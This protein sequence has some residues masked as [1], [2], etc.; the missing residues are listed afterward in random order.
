MVMV[1]NRFDKIVF[2]KFKDIL[3][4]Y[5]FKLFLNPCKLIS[6]LKDYKSIQKSIYDDIMKN[7]I[8]TEK[9]NYKTVEEFCEF[10]NTFLK[11]LPRKKQRYIDKHF[12]IPKSLLENVEI[13][14][15]YKYIP[16]KNKVCYC[17][18]HSLPY[19]SD[20]YATRSRYMAECL[21]SCFDVVAVTKPGFPWD[22]K[23]CMQKVDTVPMREVQNNIVY[24]RQKSPKSSFS[25]RKRYLNVI[26]S[27]RKVFMDEKPEYVIAA[28]NYL[29]AFPVLLAAKSLGIPF[30]YEVRGLWEVTKISKDIEY[31]RSLWYLFE[32]YFE[33][34]V[35]QLAD[36]VFTLTTAMKQELTE[37]GVEESNIYLTPNCA[38]VSIFKNSE[39]DKELMKQLN[40]SEDDVVIGYV[41]TIQMYEGLDDLIRACALFEDKNI[42]FKLLIIGGVSVADNDKCDEHLQELA[43]ELGLTDK[44]IMTGRVPVKDVSRYYSLMDITPFG[45]KNLPVCD[46]VSPIKPLEAMAMKKTV[47]VPTLRALT[48]IVQDDVTGLHFEK[49]NEVSYAKVLEHAIKD[50]DLRL[51][52][53]EQASLW[54]RD[55][56]Q[57]TK[58]AQVI[59]SVVKNNNP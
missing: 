25:L 40:I 58:N 36:G 26:N 59:K 48:E 47:I 22:N 13:S 43:K 56:R 33:T 8:Y 15:N 54:V 5:D 20:G 9:Y 53:G 18:N 3:S 37:R 46:L 7:D 30:Y 17:L 6:F 27:W 12:M 11:L 28:S 35:C 51:R 44:L 19:Q 29:N 4:K 16:Q 52:L 49:G 1:L 41:G 23:K 2:E 38:D 45:R 34:K 32:R 10:W 50:A 55:N 24:C 21:S 31:S 42:N 39:K 57:W 14:K